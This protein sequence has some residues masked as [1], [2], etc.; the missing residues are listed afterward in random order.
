MA[1]GALDAA[2]N[3]AAT[4]QGPPVGTN[5]TPAEGPRL[6]FDESEVARLCAAA[7]SRTRA[8]VL[9]NEAAASRRTLEAFG[10]MLR[11]ELAAL[12][13]AQEQAWATARARLGVMLADSFAAVA[14]GFVNSLRRE[15]LAREIADRLAVFRADAPVRVC[16]PPDLAETL[17]ASLLSEER[18][19]VGGIEVIPEPACAPTGC[20][21]E[22]KDTVVEYDAGRLIEAITAALHNVLGAATAELRPFKGPE[23]GGKGQLDK[24]MHDG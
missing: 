22:A 13:L 2:E 1:W 4:P 14:P 15:L 6:L 12:R 23:P 19:V 3:R 17:A 21:I 18:E 20:R 9:A 24:E 7:V 10:R 16:V 5:P 11:A 8:R